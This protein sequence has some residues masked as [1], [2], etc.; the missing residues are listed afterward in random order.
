VEGRIIR[1]DESGFVRPLAATYSA[2]DLDSFGDTLIEIRNGVARMRE[3]VRSGETPTVNEGPWCRYCASFSA[4]PA[5]AA[6]VRNML[7]ELD[8]LR[9]RIAM[10]TLEERGKAWAKYKQIKPVFEAVEAA[11]KEAAAVDSLPLPNGKWVG[12]ISYPKQSFSKPR[13][14]ALLRELG[15]TDDQI[16]SLTTTIVVDQIRELKRP[17]RRPYE[18]EVDEEKNEAVA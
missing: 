13:A 10:M 7:P 14:Y 3:V 1:I 11:L 4:C 9:G 8:A 6:L 12:E 18:T 17:P 16:A 15:A 2:F 5:K